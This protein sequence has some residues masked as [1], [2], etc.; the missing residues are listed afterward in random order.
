VSAPAGIFDLSARR[1]ATMPGD[2]ERTETG[3]ASCFA[4]IHGANVRYV[5]KWRTWLVWANG[6][7][8]RDDQSVLVTELAKDVG[9]HGSGTRANRA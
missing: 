9:R 4:A 1:S 6:H 3:N 7:W 2:L 5:P 8:H